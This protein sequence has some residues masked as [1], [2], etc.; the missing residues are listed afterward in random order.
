MDFKL[1]A[2]RPLEG[3]GKD[4]RKN[5]KE[6]YLY[7]LY[8]KYHLLDENGDQIVD[9][10]EVV[11]IR[12]VSKV[13]ADLYSIQT[14][15]G[16][17]LD[18]NISAI[19]GKN[20][21]GKSTI[22]EIFF[23]ILY[24]FSLNS[25]LLH[26]NES[27]LLEE[28]GK[29]ESDLNTFTKQ[30]VDEKLYQR[31]IRFLRKIVT[32][33]FEPLRNMFKSYE[34]CLKEQIDNDKQAAKRKRDIENELKEIERLRGELKAE[35]IFKISKTFISLKVSDVFSEGYQIKI[36]DSASEDDSL[37]KEFINGLETDS[38]F[39][40]EAFLS[41]LFFYTVAIN[42]SNYSLNSE[43]IGQWIQ[44][45]FHKND[46]YRSP[47]VLNPMRT[48]GEF[49]IV[50]E[51]RF[52]KYRLLSNLL[53]G[54]KDK[55][56]NEKIYLTPSQ[57]VKYIRFTRNNKKI[58]EYKIDDNGEEIRGNE[59]EIAIVNDLYATY[60]PGGKEGVIREGAGKEIFNLVSNYVIQKVKRI[61]ENY[62]GFDYP[63]DIGQ[64]PLLIKKLSNENSHIT[65]KLKQAIFFIIHNV[66]AQTD[67]T[68][69]GD[70][71]EVVDEIEISP[72]ELLLWMGSP[73]YQ[74]IISHLPPSFFFIEI[75]LESESGETST[76]DHL[77]SGEQQYIHVL[78]S[79]LYHII[80]LQSVSTS[81][82]RL[83]YRA[84]NIIFDEV[85]LYFH[86]EMQRRFIYDLRLAIGGLY[87]SG[88]G[89]FSGINIL[90]L[91][92]SPFILSDIPSDSVLRLT[93]GEDKKAIAKDSPGE[94]FAANINDLLADDFFLNDTLLGKFA[95]SKILELIE[96]IRN[97]NIG[98]REED[99][100]NLIGDKYLQS[101]IR[102]FLK[103]SLR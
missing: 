52:A 97:G 28:L 80:N 68:F 67:I 13:P 6:N 31:I 51:N 63:T 25:G 9:K 73:D 1:I 33:R 74:D 30:N 94:T 12:T 100:I 88:E 7:T 79:I 89:G 8:K 66:F 87:L 2:L 38:I 39:A 27:D 16:R 78:Q 86:P 35:I 40:S 44:W 36:I 21:S 46:G 45:L 84:L 92:H 72:E 37:I 47:V 59:I 19:V 3:C 83:S 56:V 77:S 62:D 85:E 70:H 18:V 99:M 26:P 69:F 15:D 34:E 41:G 101:T 61:C 93:T 22:A 81:G 29:I 90:F 58:T 102:N 14:R 49:S 20:G 48:K 75:I 71:N 42:Y 4:F 5:L 55:K 91:T 64:V 96:N 32:V 54:Y 24:V 17:I 10:G 103:N 65:F 23:G 95:D 43:V 60:F 76:F 53:A 98:K 11:A 50:K 82:D 57:Y